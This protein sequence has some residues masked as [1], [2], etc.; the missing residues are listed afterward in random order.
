MGRPAAFRKIA[1]VLCERI[2]TGEYPIGG[3]LPSESELSREFG[4]ARTT[5]RRALIAMEAK[6]LIESI[7]AKGRIVKGG[8]ETPHY[9]YQAIADDLREQIRQQEI[10]PGSSLPS[11]ATLR[12]RYAASRNTVRHALAVL[13]SDGWLLRGTGMR[14]VVRLQGEDAPH[15]HC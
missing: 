9:R 2:E 8:Q 15:C 10:P 12:R 13:E 1:S 3:S 11:E 5:L 4:V 6:G 14:R 7:P